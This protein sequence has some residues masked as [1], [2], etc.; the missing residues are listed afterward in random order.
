MKEKMDRKTFIK[1][2]GAGSVILASPMLLS[3]VQDLSVQEISEME[4]YNIPRPMDV[5]IKIKPVYGQR[6]PNEVHEGPCRSDSPVGWNRNEEISKAK[7]SFNKWVESVKKNLCDKAIMLQPT[8]VQYA[9][10]HRIDPKYWTEV[11]KDLKDTDLFLV[12]YRVPGIEKFN[13]PVAILG[14]ACAS[15]D[16]PAQLRNRGIESYG[17][18]DFEELNKIITLLQVRKALQQTKMLIVTDGPWET[19]YN[20]VHSNIADLKELNQRLSIDSQFISFKEFFNEMDFVIKNKNAQK[21]AN[22]ITDKLIN[23]AQNV[24]MKKVDILSSVNYYLSVKKLMEKYNCNSFSATCQELCVA[25]YAAKYKITPCLTHTLLKDQGY[26]SS[27]EA[28]TNVLVS[29]MLQMYLTNKS[30]YMG[31]TLIHNKDKNLLFIHHNVPGIK[32]K[33]FDQP[34]LPYEIRNFTERGWGATVRYDFS[35]DKGEKVTFCRLNPAATKLLIVAGEMEGCQGF[36]MNGCSLR[37][38]IKVKDVMEYFH[39][40]VNFGHHFS[41]VYGDS[42]AEMQ[43]LAEILNIET[44]VV[45]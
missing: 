28:D 37:A 25:G 41:M 10:D 7:N 19:E 22:T 39:N 12:N 16:I 23:N 3:H 31:N 15:L 24:H 32:M 21:F 30:P 33:G 44:V 1:T 17:L 35:L 26:P 38:T 5:K 4:L 2:A 14:N 18:Y 9:G 45:S 11:E 8:Y 40:A 27:C 29:M 20:S 43:K 42:V 6:I 36:N 34:D 13:K